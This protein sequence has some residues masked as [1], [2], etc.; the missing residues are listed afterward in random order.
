MN[1]GADPRSAALKA[2]PEGKVVDFI[3]GRLLDDT[4]EE[5]VRQNVETTVAKKKP[6]LR[7]GQ[8][9]VRLVPER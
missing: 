3:S 7:L 2:I 1:Q 8:G 4:P 6:L 9:P 5:Y